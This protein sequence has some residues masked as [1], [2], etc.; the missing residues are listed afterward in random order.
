MKKVIKGKAKVY[1]KGNL[2]FVLPDS[3]DEGVVIIA[4]PEAFIKA[5]PMLRELIDALDTVEA[6]S[7]AQEAVQAH[8]RLQSKN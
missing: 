5:A 6:T 2:T 8:A 4:T 7:D 3:E 1:E